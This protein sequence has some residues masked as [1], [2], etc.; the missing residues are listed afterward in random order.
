MGGACP[1]RAS[2]CRS[3]P[4]LPSPARGALFLLA[5][6]LALPA[7]AQFP[8][9]P[10]S[11]P[12]HLLTTPEGANLPADA[13]EHDFPVL[14][15]LHRDFFD[16]NQARPDGADIRFSAE[17]QPLAHQVEAWDPA[18]G[19]ASIWVRVPVIRGNARQEITL[20]WG[21]ARAPSAS[22]GEAVF[23]ESNGFLSVWHMTEPLNDSAG[24]VTS[25]NA[26]TTPTEGIIGPARHFD[27]GQGVF[28]G[29]SI[30]NYP[31]GGS[32][33]STEAWFRPEQPNS[34]LLAWGN[35]EA[36]G[37][38]VLQFRSPPHVR[39]DCYFSDGNVAGHSRLPMAEW[40]QVVHTYE[41]GDARIYVNGVLDGESRRQGAPLNVRSPA[42]LWLGGW[43]HHYDFTGDLDEVR[44]SRV[45]RSADWIRLQYENQKPM[46]TLVGWVVPPGD[47]FAVSQEQ[48]TLAEGGQ[49][50]VAAQAGGAL[51]VYWILN[52]DGRERVVAVDRLACTVEAG[53]VT[54]D[55]TARLQ[56]KAIYADGIKTK[57]IALKIREA[58]PEPAFSLNAL[59]DWDGRRT[60]AVT[61]V[62]SN[63]A[64]LR[65]KG[66][67]DLTYTWTV[68]GLA[69][70]KRIE[71]DRLV[72]QR[73]QNS[74]Q[75]CVTLAL[76]NGGAQTTQSVVLKVHEP[77]VDPWV[78]RSPDPDERPEDNQFYARDD[79]NEGMLHCNGTLAEP[80]DSV[81]LRVYADETRIANDERKPGADRAYAF[82]AKLQPGLIKYRMELGTRSGDRETIVHTA[83]NLVCG[84]AYLI[85]GQSNALATDT[86]ETAPADTSDWIR[87]FGSTGGDP[88]RARLHLWGN[89][90]WKDNEERL[91]LGYWGMELARRLVASQ[92]IPICIINGAVGGTRIDQH[93]RN[94]ADPED[95]STIYG[96][97]L[98][99]VRQARLTHGI[100]GI[101]WHQG[102]N[103]QGA[104]G[105]TGRFGWETY[106]QYFVELSA[107]WKEDYP[108]LQ[109]YY[110]FQIWPKACAM[111]VDG[112]DN[113]L[114]EVQRTLPTLYSNMSIMSTLGIK[115]PGGCHYPLEGWA[116][117][118]RLIQPLIERDNYGKV[119]S[120][121]I[122]PSNL[123]KA[124]YATEQ[125][126]TIT[127]EFDQPVVWSDDLVSQFHLDGEAGRI[128]SGSVSGKVL[129]L[130][131]TAPWTAGRITYLDS[132]SW[133]PDHLLYGAN[134]IAALTFCNVPIIRE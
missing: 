35:E 3:A 126:D 50:T 31:H 5:L 98:W 128:A 82:S 116:E 91:Q 103:D 40:T 28:G 18:R 6:M 102:E 65:A 19:E 121:G 43:Y 33:H 30:T 109:H 123:L 83:T 85:Q 110:L 112:S 74:G 10:H 92:Q 11:G 73:A 122:T 89:A 53:R 101:L 47:G 88:G 13:S 120:D 15:R 44:V 4:D 104:D 2:A 52:R 115:P 25:T 20:H 125:H 133:S 77:T 23:N 86:G 60:V 22:N 93:Q 78:R 79:R 90:V 132:R 27:R 32:P 49:V 129:T 37:K 87:T 69:V 114:R 34:T 58:I 36:Q 94:P 45:A 16:F 68:S 127:L 76:G 61:P 63:L 41:N 26:R 118:A 97:L 96:R 100:R 38:V 39:T 7:A 134:G 119:F 55:Q 105:P 21:N 1:P 81:F 12:L 75:L 48:V 106:Q 107:A 111:G 62:I 64:A 54:G 70:I 95:V 108:N 56:F 17:G 9:W 66:A 42:R 46:Q 67:D 84:D 117:F 80:A 57:D 99:R 24:T 71:P 29:D 14:V 131:L 59:A 130:R 124:A 8:D 72:L 51:K 113:L